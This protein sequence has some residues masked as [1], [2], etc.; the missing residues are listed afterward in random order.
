MQEP[1]IPGFLVS[2]TILI[3]NLC[4]DDSDTNSESQRCEKFDSDT[5]SQT[6]GCEKFDSDTDTKTWQV[7]YNET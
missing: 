4:L 7:L 2:I 3:P 5:N 1:A 6:Q